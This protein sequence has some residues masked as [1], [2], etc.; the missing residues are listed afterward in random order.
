MQHQNTSYT[1]FLAQK[2]Q[3]G[4]DSGFEPLWMP[5]FLFPFQ[6]H[7]VDWAIRKGRSAIFADC[8]LGKTPMELVWAHNV[9]RKNN[10]RVLMLTPLAVAQQ[11]IR[12]AEKFSIEAHRSAGELHPGINITNYEK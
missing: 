10:K 3:Y 9:V 1:E 11:M 5:G 4:Q 12:E 6:Q 7:L 2:A 8:G